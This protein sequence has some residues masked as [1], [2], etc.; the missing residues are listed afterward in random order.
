LPDFPQFPEELILTIGSWCLDPQTLLNLS[1][2]CKKFARI[3][4]TVDCW[5]DHHWG[6]GYD[7]GILAKKAQRAAVTPEQKYG[8]NGWGLLVKSAFEKAE[9]PDDDHMTQWNKGKPTPHVYIQA[10]WALNIPDAFEK[11]QPRGVKYMEVM[12]DVLTEHECHNL[13]LYPWLNDEVL[14]VRVK[15]VKSR[16][17]QAL[18]SA[19]E[20]LIRMWSLPIAVMS[21]DD[22]VINNQTSMSE[23][24][25]HD[26]R[27]TSLT[28]LT[29]AFLV[30]NKFMQLD[31]ISQMERKLY[32]HPPMGPEIWLDANGDVDPTGTAWISRVKETWKG[33]VYVM[34]QY[35]TISRTNKCSVAR[36]ILNREPLRMCLDFLPDGQ[37]AGR[38]GD[39]GGKFLITGTYKGTFVDLRKQYIEDDEEDVYLATGHMIPWG[40]YGRWTV[41]NKPLETLGYWCMWHYEVE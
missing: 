10:P 4:R 37:I 22:A 27:K 12:Y 8:P 23:L 19:S 9:F 14:K 7:I 41:P 35:A 40:V 1:S 32:P 24:P 13:E 15:D 25:Q 34:G 30:V 16:Y 39:F 21:S 3:L 20:V 31:H 29:Y 36:P 26:Y 2:T 17:L 38:G 6:R 5:L 11:Y 18:I 33:R 28:S